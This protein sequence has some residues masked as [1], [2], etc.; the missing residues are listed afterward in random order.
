MLITLDVHEGM[1]PSPRV[2]VTVTSL[3]GTVTAVRVV[4]VS[5]TGEVAVR[6]ADPISAA[7]S[8]FVTDFEVPLGVDVSYRVEG[9]SAAGVLVESDTAGPVTVGGISARQVIIQDPL[10]P[11]LAV[12]VDERD[13]FAETLTHS[14]SSSRYR[15]GARTVVLMGEQGLLEGVDLSVACDDTATA[16]AIEAVLDG[17]VALFRTLDPIGLPR[18]FYAAVSSRDRVPVDVYWGGSLTWLQLVGDE[19]SRD[20]LAT[21]RPLITW[22]RFIDFYA[23]WA[24]LIAAHPTWLSLMTDP[25]PEV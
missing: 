11:S 2:D 10:V 18:C 8:A 17:G 14:R 4:Q 21:L 3:S 16:D 9:L 1:D 13:T 15:A 6:D 25:P 24:D 23:T 7:G 5:S 20:R 12:V 22:Q 19:V